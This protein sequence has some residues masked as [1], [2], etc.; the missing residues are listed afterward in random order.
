M[1]KYTQIHCF[2]ILMSVFIQSSLFRDVQYL[3]GKIV[4][5]LC[6][7]FK[8]WK[9]DIPCIDWKIQCCKYLPYSFISKYNTVI[10]ITLSTR[11]VFL[12]IWLGVCV[13]MKC[14]KLILKCLRQRELRHSLSKEVY[15][16][17]GPTYCIKNY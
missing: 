16:M 6:R 7:N 14:D 3:W 17:T 15:E 13:F 11:F 4:T 1:T 9:V 8:G 5:L 12:V 10:I 2:C